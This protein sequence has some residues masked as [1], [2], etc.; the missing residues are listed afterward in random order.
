MLQHDDGGVGMLLRV[1]MIVDN[2][3]ACFS[4]NPDGSDGC[5]VAFAARE[6][7]AGENG[8][9]LDGALVRLVAVYSPEHENRTARRLYHHNRGYAVG[10]VVQFASNINS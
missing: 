2:E 8:Q 5:H 7:A 6:Y 4:L 9:R 3:L 1:R 10:E